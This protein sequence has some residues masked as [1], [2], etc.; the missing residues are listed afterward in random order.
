MFRVEPNR[1]ALSVGPAI[2]VD[3]RPIF[4]TAAKAWRQLRKALFDTYRPELHYLRGPGPKWREKHGALQ[5]TRSGALVTRPPNA[6]L[7]AE[8]DAF[9]DKGEYRAGGNRPLRAYASHLPTKQTTTLPVLNALSHTP[10]MCSA[11]ARVTNALQ[12]VLR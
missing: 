11:L 2:S 5:T 1:S 9:R 7:V 8:E 10:A 4:A 12:S 3:T 6:V